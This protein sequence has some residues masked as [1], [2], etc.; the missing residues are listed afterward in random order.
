MLY[1]IESFGYYKIGFTNNLKERMKAYSSMT[2]KFTL[3]GIRNGNKE[4]EHMFH[5]YLH[6]FRLGNKEWFTGLNNE[7]IEKLTKLFSTNENTDFYYEIKDIA[8]KKEHEELINIGFQN[9]IN[10]YY[11]SNF[12]EKYE[13][14]DLKIFKEYLTLKEINS[15]RYNKE[16]MKKVCEDKKRFEDIINSVL[17]EGFMSS[18]N[19]KQKM[20]VVFS[21]NNISIAPK[22]TLIEKSTTYD[23]KKTKKMKNGEVIHGYLITKKQDSLF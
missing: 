23:I 3:I 1:F 12:D 15:L 17:E 14:D 19:I 20:S 5:V 18:A 16:E 7:T 21:E 10:L 13:D 11:E 22:A 9:K 6:E 2:P 4:E 8:Y